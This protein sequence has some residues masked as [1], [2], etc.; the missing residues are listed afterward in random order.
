MDNIKQDICLDSIPQIFLVFFLQ[1][2]DEVEGGI[3]YVDSGA[4]EALHFM[5]GLP[6]ILQLG[7]RAV[8][9]L[10]NASPLDA[11]RT[12]SLSLCLHL[13]FYVNFWF[14]SGVCIIQ[15][16]WIVA[17]WGSIGSGMEARRAAESGGAHNTAPQ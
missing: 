16:G 17:C 14:R 11:V 12:L 1:V 4:G 6:F 9:S 7:V 8:C 15:K 3:L 2:A 5:G 13:S 10:E